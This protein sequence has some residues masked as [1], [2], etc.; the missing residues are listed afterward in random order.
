MNNRKE[1]LQ[2]LDRLLTIMDELREQCPWDKKQTM[3]SLRHLTIEETYELGDAILD[4]DLNEVKMELGDVLLH[5]IF[6]SKIGSETNDFDI[7]DVA[8]AI[9]DKLVNRHPHIYGDVKVLN[10]DDVKRNWEQ[11]KLKEGKKSVLEGVPRSLPA[12]VK[13]NRIQDKVAG[14]GFDWEEP[15]QVFE[16]VQE[17]LGELQE[18]VQKGDL[19]KIEAEFGDVLFSMIN[20]ARF[21]GVNPENALERTNKKFIKRFQYLENSAKEIGK[22]MKDMTLEEMDIYWNKAKTYE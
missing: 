7:A 20:Y 22:D 17:E 11:I 6:Y 5:I 14:V 8:N 21:L 12:L 4:N 16:K 1:Q 10:E 3:Q 18:E 9:C 13:A 15:Q 19:E 2:A